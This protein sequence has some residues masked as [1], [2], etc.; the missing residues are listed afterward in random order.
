MA[1]KKKARIGDFII[2]KLNLKKDQVYKFLN[3]QSYLDDKVGEIA[4]NEKL[5]TEKELEKILE[6][7]KS[8]NLTFGNAA[9]SLG[10]MKSSQLKLILDIQAQNKQRIGELL[11]QENIITQENLFKI[12]DEYY[13][14]NKEQF[15]IISF[16]H[17]SVNNEIQKVLKP[18]HYGFNPCNDE[19]KLSALI[20]KVK[21][22]LIILDKEKGKFVKVIKKIKESK[23][24][25]HIKIALLSRSKEN[26]RMVTG[27]EIGID[28]F[29]PLPFEAKHFI[30]I[31]IDSEI[32]HS[33]RLKKRILVVDDS[34]LVRLS[35]TQELQESGFQILTAK[36]GEEAVEIALLEKPDLIT[37]D[38]NMP[39]MNGYEACHAMRTNLITKDIPIIILTSNNTQEEREKGFEVGAIEYF[40]KPFTKGYLRNYI[41][42]LLASSSKTRVEKVLVADDSLICRNIFSSVFTKYGYEH[43]IVDNGKAVLDLLERGFNP[44]TI[45][46]D[47]QMPV[48]NGF[49]VCKILKQD[50]RYR[51]IP[52]IIVT[53][54]SEKDDVLKAL[55]I[56]ADDYL[57]K[58]FDGDELIARIET[59]IRSFS[60]LDKLQEQNFLLNE[61]KKA[62]MEAQAYSRNIIDSS[63]DMII[64]C[65]N[66]NKIVEFNRAAERTFG[67]KKEEL[68]GKD[69][70]IL[71]ATEEDE[72]LMQK[73]LKDSGT[74]FGES[75][76][77]RK[78]GAIFPT[79]ISASL[80]KDAHG[81]VIYGTMGVSRDIT[82]LK[83]AEME[84]KKARVKAER[85]ALEAEKANKAKSEFLATMSHEIRTPMN[86][87]IGMA[88]FLEDTHLSVEQK[89]Y[90][91]TLKN[92]G[93][94]LLGLIND[95]LDI[96]KIESGH[97]ELE[98][99]DF[100]IRELIEKTLEI[101]AMRTHHKGLELLCQIQEDIPLFHIG[102]PNRLRQIIINLISN[103]VK[104]TA[105]GEI[106][107]TLEKVEVTNEANIL[108]FSVSDT[109]I[110]IPDDKKEKVFKSFSQAD[111]ST[112]REYGGT[113]L[114]LAISKQLVEKMN[115]SIW[116]EGVYG[117][118]CIFNFTIE[119]GKSKKNEEVS[120]EQKGGAIKDCTTLIIDHNE[121]NQKI[122]QE[123][124]NSFGVKTMTAIEKNV[125]KKLE[126]NSFDVL[127][128]DCHNFKE[129]NCPLKKTIKNNP[130]LA[131]KTIMMLTTDN[132]LKHKE[133]M[134]D[135][136]IIQFLIKPVKH[137][138]LIRGITEIITLD[139]PEKKEALA[140]KEK[141]AKKAVEENKETKILNIL[142]VEDNMVNQAIAKK[143]LALKGHKTTVAENGKIAVDKFIEGGFDLI[144]MD[145][146][147]PVMDGYEATKTIRK[148]EK[149]TKSNIPIIAMTAMAFGEDKQKCL[150]VGMNGY[151]SKPIRRD[152]LFK[153]L[154]GFY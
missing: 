70:S 22:H 98:Y 61:H 130:A 65:D 148:K 13:S 154:E 87:I 92:A 89:E 95:I 137:D 73:G 139:S 38:I 152:E 117:E 129:N 100:N 29:L 7:Q 60:L 57:I 97:L 58:P 40:T 37:M 27:Y 104:F 35:I 59:H 4:L 75:L 122:L 105:K 128:I 135:L 113:G 66:D 141:A 109:G 108:C 48:M 78:D 25:S 67:Y 138:S 39:I 126:E 81:K 19:E 26:F 96:S 17:N 11:V 64:S 49:E 3:M 41:S 144:L 153:A 83:L 5:I 120:K 56:G 91:N 71:Y 111:S 23:N 84:V 1:E 82:K 12:L 136:G 142:L 68:T 42:H 103:A 6:A 147:M 106:K 44:S 45:L 118:G 132:R 53:G 110:G 80:L 10:F 46:L 107:L 15:N 101:M 124:L 146:N 143:T 93:E 85:Y 63:I 86:A 30:N 16:A 94:N 145:I 151:L 102:D 149:G 112:S 33:K 8:F 2:Q 79:S 62:L 54:S 28:Y 74:Y 140:K 36:N 31:I 43:E 115:G 133:L 69:I 21:P 88:D 34:H 150:D 90:V 24:S 52:I 134:E 47:Y 51:N 131:K 72:K 55:K 114:G 121:T 77:K 20:K 116:I 123:T 9:I 14:E 18:Y 50:E 99:I 76:N 127:L 119:L 125:L 32:Q